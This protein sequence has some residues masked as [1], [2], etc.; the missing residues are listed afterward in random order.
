MLCGMES[1]PRSPLEHDDD[2][3]SDKVVKPSRAKRIATTGAVLASLPGI[4]HA[5]THEQAQTTRL[6]PVVENQAVTETRHTTEHQQAR[7]EIPQDE[8]YARGF[9][10]DV[11]AGKT[12]NPHAVTETIN[13][14]NQHIPA[15]SEVTNVQVT[16]MASAEDQNL[17]EQG[18]VQTPSSPNL[19]LA[20]TRANIFTAEFDPRLR[21]DLVSRGV[22]LPDSVE[23]EV[24]AVE[25]SLTDP[26]M[27]SIQQVIEETGY[28]GT[29]GQ[30]I[31]A[32]NTGQV[33]SAEARVL[34]D[35][36]LRERRKVEVL[37]DFDK[38]VDRAVTV[39]VQKPTL[40]YVSE[41]TTSDRTK[42]KKVITTNELI[43]YKPDNPEPVQRIDTDLGP[44]PEPR[45][46]PG[47]PDVVPRVTTTPGGG[48]IVEPPPTPPPRPPRYVPPRAHEQRTITPNWQTQ[49]GYRS[50]P[51]THKQPRG[52][53]FNANTT[54]SRQSGQEGLSRDRGGSRRGKR[55]N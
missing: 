23:T 52:F 42:D 2:S 21:Q 13:T 24:E 39:V 10:Y 28:Q 35:H 37:I 4:A 32:Y 53:N 51:V 19:E 25:D 15:G 47:T 26:E 45:H 40:R 29:I 12:V 31:E 44:A 3:R 38:P 20:E 6:R 9:S 16:G 54:R 36:F 46:Q 55:L 49:E 5:T 11:N 50:A 48:E 14:L 41:T 43:G 22:E 17:A 8:M 27:E 18:G 33:V 1:I 30:L 34:L 7:V